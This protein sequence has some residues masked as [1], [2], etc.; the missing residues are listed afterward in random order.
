M[1]GAAHHNR[2]A[3]IDPGTGAVL[4]AFSILPDYNVNY[5][6]LDISPVSGHLFLV[7]SSES[8]VAE[9]T[10]DGVFVTENPLPSGVG[11]LSG[12]ALDNDLD[13]AWVCNT[14]GLVFKLGDFPMEVPGMSGAA[15]SIVHPNPASDRLWV[16]MPEGRMLRSAG[17]IDPMGREVK[18][19]AAS[20][21]STSSAMAFDL[22]GVPPGRYVLMMHLD[23]GMEAHGLVIMP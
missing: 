2:V 6:D 3:E 22:Q 5:G 20:A 21:V 7:S 1:R 13:G 17:L 23:S 19:L 16:T 9:F 11:G 4:Q 14:S 18:V 12:I 10:P 8:T 15:R